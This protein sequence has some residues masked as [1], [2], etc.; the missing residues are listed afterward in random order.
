[1]R[2]KDREV[3]DFE[4]IREIIDECDTIR[5]GFQDGEYPYIVPL[6]FGYE[7]EGKQIYFYVHGALAGKKADLM[8]Q[9]KKCSF[10]MDCAHVLELIPKAKD[11]TMRYKSFMGKADIELLEGEERQHGIDIM[12]DRYEETRDFDYNRNV[13]AHTLLAKLTVTE[14]SG[15]I[16]PVNGSPD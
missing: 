10:E 2:R 3:K 16:N 14:Y 1:M 13:V 12:M 4:V 6:S 9:N 7:L 15:K 5:L 8:R 11:V